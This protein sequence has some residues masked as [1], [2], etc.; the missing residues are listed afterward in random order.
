MMKN[1]DRMDCRDRAMDGH[2]KVRGV[3]G[4]VKDDRIEIHG[5]RMNIEIHEGMKVMVQGASECSLGTTDSNGML[6][7]CSKTLGLRSASIPVGNETRRRAKQMRDDGGAE[8]HTH[9]IGSSQ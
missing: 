9:N 5:V 4:M 6:S 3:R 1:D 7:G 8:M 2:D